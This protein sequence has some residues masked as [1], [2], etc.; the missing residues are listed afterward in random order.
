[1]YTDYEL[2]YYDSLYHSGVKG[3]KLGFRK[4]ATE[5]AKSIG[6][7]LGYGGLS[8]Y[9]SK[10]TKQYFFGGSGRLSGVIGGHAATKSWRNEENYKIRKNKKLTKEEKAEYQKINN[11]SNKIANGIITAAMYRKQIVIGAKLA[12]NLIKIAALNYIEYKNKTPKAVKDLH[13]ERIAQMALPP[14]R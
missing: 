9:V 7:Q 3:M 12:K 2:L 5:Y 1:M 6:Q 8:A 11:R 13:I 4:R 14:A 10:N